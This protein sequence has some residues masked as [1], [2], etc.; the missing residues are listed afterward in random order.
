MIL[1]VKNKLILF[2][3][4]LIVSSMLLVALFL[5]TRPITDITGRVILSTP[6]NYSGFAQNLY[7]ITLLAFVLLLLAAV[8]IIHIIIKPL[9]Q[10][11]VGT[12]LVSEGHFEQDIPHTSND[13]FGRL[14]DS[15]NH[16]IAKLRAE[17]LY[18]QRAKEAVSSERSKREFI[19]E[20][21]AEG[22]IVISKDNKVNVFNRAA[23]HIFNVDSKKIIGKHILQLKKYGLDN[24][25]QEYDELNSHEKL[26]ANTHSVYLASSLASRPHSQPSSSAIFNQHKKTEVEF[27]VKHLDKVV[28]AI[29]SPLFEYSTSTSKNNILANSQTGFKTSSKSNCSANKS[30]HY[31]GA[32]CIIRDV[33]FLRHMENLKA[34]FLSRVSHELKTPLTNIKG[35]TSLLNLGKFGEINYRQSKAVKIIDEESDRLLKLIENLLDLSKLE[36]GKA[37]LETDKI[38]IKECLECVECNN[39]LEMAKERGIVVKTKIS[40]ALPPVLADK[41]KISA[42]LTNLLSNAIKFTEGKCIGNGMQ[43]NSKSSE[44]ALIIIQAKKKQDFVEV[45][46][47]DNGIGMKTQDLDQIFDKFYQAEDPLVREKGGAGLGLSISKKIIE[48]HGGCINVESSLGEGTE[49][50]FT[51]PIYP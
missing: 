11:I 39:I 30:M 14:V 7:T 2:S 27:K 18:G 5:G 10:V 13:E 1:S 51:L 45:K 44:G 3:V 26:Y 21:M 49:V 37:E 28:N 43:N 6:L 17:R 4:F 29:V 32:V 22:V 42:V 8:F 46:I 48:L 19:I 40:S 20:S 47:K 9:D 15:Y 41:Q 16:M 23:E 33:T 50:S 31:N 34:D 35:Y 24:L 36:S 38:T 12:Q 25:H